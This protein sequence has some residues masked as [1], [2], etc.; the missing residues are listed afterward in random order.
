LG[1]TSG[2][3]QLP[4]SGIEIRLN[5]A[6]AEFIEK[7]RLMRSWFAVKFDLESLKS[8]SGNRDHAESSVRI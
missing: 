1:S 8:V 4:Q 2:F 6:I 7:E 5:R 3:R